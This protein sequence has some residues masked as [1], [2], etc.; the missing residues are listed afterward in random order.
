MLNSSWSWPADADAEVAGGCALNTASA[1][2]HRTLHPD[3]AVYTWGGYPGTGPKGAKQ[4]SDVHGLAGG[5]ETRGRSPPS[6]SPGPGQPGYPRQQAPRLIEARPGASLR[7][8]R[9]SGE[10]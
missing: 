4:P 8:R 5:G 9:G 10:L 3:A 7:G 1:G 6:R 2:Y